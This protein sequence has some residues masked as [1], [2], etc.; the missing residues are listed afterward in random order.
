MI[1]PLTED[2]VLECA[3]C[4]KLI[5][6]K[7]SWSPADEGICSECDTEVT[8]RP[9][10]PT[11]PCTAEALAALKKTKEHSADPHSKIP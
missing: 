3:L 11:L 7:D 2:D 1:T 10:P 4:S 6:F 8:G 5:L 9:H